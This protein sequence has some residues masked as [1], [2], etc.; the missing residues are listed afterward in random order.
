MAQRL[1]ICGT[2]NLAFTI[3][4]LLASFGALLCAR[5]NNTGSTAPATFLTSV[6]RFIACFHNFAG[7]ASLTALSLTV[8]VA[9]ICQWNLKTI[10]SLTQGAIVWAAAL[11]VC[12][13]QLDSGS[14]LNSKQVIQTHYIAWGTFL[15]TPTRRWIGGLSILG[16]FSGLFIAHF[17]VYVIAHQAKHAINIHE[18]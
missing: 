17:Y 10:I 9:V 15:G 1:I 8:L 11:G 6:K 5:K 3:F 12:P 16:L 4:P 2:F 14:C 18:Q 7:D 13:L